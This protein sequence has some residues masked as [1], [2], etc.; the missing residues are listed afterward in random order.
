[1][2]EVRAFSAVSQTD[3]KFT[4]SNN[5]TTLI[6]EGKNYVENTH[7]HTHEPFTYEIHGIPSF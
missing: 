3:A 2:F 5:T 4:S 7:T 1:M 6:V